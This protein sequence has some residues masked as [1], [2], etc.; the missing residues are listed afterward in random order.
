[1]NLENSAIYKYLD[2]C[3]SRNTYEKG[4]IQQS[5]LLG[6]HVQIAFGW[7]QDVRVR[8]VLAADADEHHAANQQEGVLIS[9]ISYEGS[10]QILIS[11]ITRDYLFLILFVRLFIIIY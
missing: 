7:R 3:V 6:S 11:K 2:V 9:S 8:P 10:Q 4:D 1:M 5:F